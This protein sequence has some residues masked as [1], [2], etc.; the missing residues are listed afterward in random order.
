MLN[1]ILVLQN[2][3]QLQIQ[4]KYSPSLSAILSPSSN[5]P[6]RFKEEGSF[7]MF[8]HGRTSKINNK[9]IK[10]TIKRDLDISAFNN[11]P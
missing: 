2:R 11:V 9:T 4:M 10:Q 3:R 8:T 5:G 1:V 6:T 7:H